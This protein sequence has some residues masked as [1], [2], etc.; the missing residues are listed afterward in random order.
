M[1]QRER[2]RSGVEGLLR[3]TQQDRRVLADR[4]EHH[5]ALEFGDHFAKDVDA[6]GLEGAQVI[7]PQGGG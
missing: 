1:E 4:I 5:R 2:N 6:L 3:Q 7:E